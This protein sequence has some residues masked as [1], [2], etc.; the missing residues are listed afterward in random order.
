MGSGLGDGVRDTGA[1]LLLFMIRKSYDEKPYRRYL[2]RMAG[3]DVHS[4]PSK[5][6]HTGRQVLRDDPESSGSLGIG[7]SEAIEFVKGG[8]REATRVGVHVLLRRAPSVHYR[9]GDE[10]P[11][12]TGR[13]VAQSDDRLR[14]RRQQFHGIHRTVRAREDRRKRHRVSRY[15][16]GLDT[17]AE[18]GRVPIR[19]GPTT[20]S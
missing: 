4:S 8:S 11:A 5:L 13:S 18:S 7:M 3:A 10:A 1:R 2:M 17:H 19:I 20:P 15:R 6:T 12:R 14:R 16:A 9:S